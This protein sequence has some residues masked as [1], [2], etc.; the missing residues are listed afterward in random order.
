MNTQDQIT[1]IKWTVAMESEAEP[2]VG[3]LAVAFCIVNRAKQWRQSISDVCF[4]AWQFSAWNTDSPTRMRLDD[5]SDEIMDAAKEAAEA[6]LFGQVPDPTNGAVYYMNVELVKAQRGGKL[7]RW[8]G[9]DT[10]P[11]S[12]VKIEH[13]TYRRSK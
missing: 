8:W 13:H 2:F 9:T 5:I 1:C 3:K 7:P 6:A 11:A 12:E 4:R 10:D